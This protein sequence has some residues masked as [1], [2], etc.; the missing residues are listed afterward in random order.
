MT[1]SKIK[2]IEI[3]GWKVGEAEDF[4]CLEQGEDDYAELAITEDYETNVNSI[5]LRHKK[6]STTKCSKTCRVRQA[7][8]NHSSLT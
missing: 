8:L 4:Q 5:L 6:V 2:G 3:S 7:G 1:K